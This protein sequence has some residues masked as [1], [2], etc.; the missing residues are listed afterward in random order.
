MNAP[1]DSAPAILPAAIFRSTITANV[2]TPWRRGLK[3]G[4]RASARGRRR[5]RAARCGA[6]AACGR[7]TWK[8]TPGPHD[9]CVE[10][11]QDVR[12][13]G[14]EVVVQDLREDVHMWGTARR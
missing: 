3:C 10:A 6:A 5:R 11:R 12:H 9:L 1:D 13:V 14:D 7:Q 8:S 4:A 2:S